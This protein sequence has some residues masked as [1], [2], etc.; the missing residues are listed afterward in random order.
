MLDALRA[1]EY[2]LPSFD[3]ELHDVDLAEVARASRV[4]H[5]R[6][7]SDAT[8]LINAFGEELLMQLQLNIHRLV[9]VYRV[10]ALD[11]LDAST[12]AVRLERWRIGA[13]HAGWK[14]RLARFPR[15]PRCGAPLCRNLLLCFRQQRFSRR[16][17]AAALLA[18]GRA[19][20]PLL[21]DRGS[22]QRHSAFAAPGRIP[23]VN[24]CCFILAGAGYSA[25][26]SLIPGT[27]RSHG[28]VV[29]YGSPEI[30]LHECGFFLRS[31]SDS[32]H[33]L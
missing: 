8:Y 1:V 25:V 29:L 9:I 6:G 2:E 12:L 18:H 24:Q 14:V 33:H 13:E 16:R 21:H 22:P 17:G 20:D 19:D 26:D 10:P 30:S 11:A 32:R 5:V 15:L 23:S 27:L 31:R 28:S 4:R 3:T 7:A